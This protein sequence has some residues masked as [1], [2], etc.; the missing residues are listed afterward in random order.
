M[1]RLAPGDPQIVDHVRAARR[2]KDGD[3]IMDVAE[4]TVGERRKLSFA[5]VVS[6]AIAVDGKGAVAAEPQIALM[7]LPQRGK[8]GADILDLVGDAVDQTLESLPPK[9]R[10]D[11]ETVEKAVER[12]VRGAVQRVWGKKPVCHVLVVEV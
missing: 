7:G 12:A 9:R 8:D 10:R 5:G 4:P 6:I 1:V 2:L 3:L 11:A